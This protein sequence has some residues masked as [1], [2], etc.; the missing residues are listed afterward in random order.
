M[1]EEQTALFLRA[2]AYGED[3]DAGG[4]AGAR[5]TGAVVM[6]QPAAT[7]W[8]LA[9]QSRAVC[10]MSGFS[11]RPGHTPISRSSPEAG[12]VIRR[13]RSRRPGRARQTGGRGT[14]T[15]HGVARYVL[16]PDNARRLGTLSEK[17]LAA[18]R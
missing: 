14:G 13:P 4:A 5:A 8:S 2:A 10:A 17:L 7:R 11:S 1:G 18:G 6:P 15:L 16:D 9:N 3:A 12:P